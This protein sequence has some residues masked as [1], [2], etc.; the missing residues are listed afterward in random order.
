MSDERRREIGDADSGG[1]DESREN[2]ESKEKELR[3]EGENY[4][5][6]KDGESESILSPNKRIK[7]SSIDR[8]S[9]LPDA[10]L[11][12]IL[13]FLRSVEEAAV[14]SVLSK[15]WQF[16]WTEFPTLCFR[17]RSDDVEDTRKLVNRIHR[18][19]V[20]RSVNYL[21]ELVIQLTYDQCFASD[22]DTWVE[23]ALRNKVKKF[24]LGLRVCDDPL[25]TIPEVMYSCQS[26]TRLCLQE[27]I[28]A[29]IKAIDWKSLTELF[30]ED[31]ELQDHV[32]QMI[33]SG[34]PVLR[35][36]HLTD[37]WGYKYLNI[38][39]QSL[40]ELKLQE[41]E[42]NYTGT[43]LE[44]SAPYLHSLCILFFPI[45][46]K[47]V[48]LK[49]I[50]SLV[51]AYIHLD[52]CHIT[53]KVMNDT[54]RLFE[55]IHHVKE[56]VIGCFCVKVLSS[57]VSVGLKLP[58]SRR[59]SL[60]INTTR[61][62]SNCISGILG[63]LETSP[64]LETLVVQSPDSIKEPRRDFR[65]V[66]KDDLSCDLSHL[67]TVTIKN[68]ADPYFDGEPMLTLARILLKRA[69]ALEEMIIDAEGKLTNF[70]GEHM[71]T[72]IRTL[73]SYPR[74]SQKS[75]VTFDRYI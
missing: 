19:L 52:Q 36:L 11:V 47:T 3:D 74:S 72:S 40:Q 62:D 34:C 71:I 48:Q 35:S 4:S 26:F 5:V 38:D 53:E 66:A 28:F 56:L 6:E 41:S 46:I 23:F 59:E 37:C 14:T 16:L 50:R 8:L 63:L 21:D 61:R 10:L 30:I 45:D 2:E 15:R 54:M 29:P 22:V 67:K 64:Y 31:V 18:T 32:I 60:T 13:S 73:N 7:E 27:C 51:R 65:P 43:L 25:Y 70:L 39:S 24:H 58:Q 33:L 55:R 20:L 1:G 49:N 69:T 57:M 42:V 17:G 44:I 75:I 9:A 68:Y 12:H